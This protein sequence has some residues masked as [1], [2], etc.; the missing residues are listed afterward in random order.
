MGLLHLASP[1]DDVPATQAPSGELHLTLPNGC[2]VE[3]SGV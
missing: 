2:R 1:D 3:G